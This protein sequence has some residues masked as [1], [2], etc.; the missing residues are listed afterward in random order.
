MNYVEQKT[1][2]RQSRIRAI[3]AVACWLATASFMVIVG[4]ESIK[5]SI[6][7]SCIAAAVVASLFYTPDY[8]HLTV[9]SRKRARW[10]IMIRW[11]IN[12]AVLLIGILFSLGAA[13]WRHAG[14]VLV[15]LA[16]LS[17]SNLMAVKCSGQYLPMYFWAT[18]AALLATLLLTSNCDPLLGAGLLAFAAHLSIVIADSRPG[19]W[20]RAVMLTAWCVLLATGLRLPLAKNFLIC[21]FVLVMVSVLATSWLVYSAQKQN[22]K[23]AQAALRE[24]VEFTG[25]PAEHIWRMWREADKELA[26]N[27]V[28][29]ELDENDAGALADWYRKNSELYMFAISGYN[30]DYKRIRSN[31]K[32]MGFARG[33]CLD[34]GAGNGEIIL[35]LARSG[36]AATYYDVDGV[37]ARFA[38]S[39][40]LQRGFDVKFAHCKQQLQTATLNGGFDTIFSLDVLEHLPDL[41]GEL[42]FLVS[43]LNGGGRLVFDLPSGS[44]KSHPMHL[45]HTVKARCLLLSW[46]LKEQRGLWQKLHL[47][48]QEKYVFVAEPEN[49]AIQDS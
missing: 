13:D 38:K 49:R 37:S 8:L 41:E 43:L 42:V 39:R 36:Y 45:N 5:F 6:L 40:A 46:G 33:A 1:Y 28:A 19:W 10:Q 14:A 4:H 26:R 48:K 11:R 3:A 18:D 20:A 24:L 29:A 35:D 44:T 22:A 7:F 30:L 34:Y 47:V 9:N 32:V 2:L 23:N 27:W 31:L 15:V 25:Y 21:A 12:A 17:G 16:W